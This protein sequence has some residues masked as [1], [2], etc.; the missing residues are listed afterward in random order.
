[1]KLLRIRPL[2]ASWVVG[3]FLGVTPAWADDLGLT[4]SADGGLI[5]GV[6]TPPAAPQVQVHQTGASGLNLA[7]HVPGLM[8]EPRTT[9]GGDFVAV[10]WPEA[11]LAGEIGAPALPVIRRFFTAPLGTTVTWTADAGNAVTLDSAAAGLTVL[12]NPVQ[13]PIPKIPGA[14]ESVPFVIDQAAYTQDISTPAERVTIEELGL[15]R[16]TRMFLLTVYPVAYNPAQ[17]AISYWPNISVE[18]SFEGSSQPPS[19]LNPMPGLRENVLNPDQ[20]PAMSRG[21]GNYLIIVASSLQS[22]ILP[23]ANAKAAQGFTVSSWVPASASNTAIKAYI[24][25]LWGGADAPDYVLLVGD[26]D[27]IPHWTGGG[28]GTPATDLNYVCMDG[29][30]SNAW[31]TPDIAIGRFAVRTTTQLQDVIDKVLLYENGPLPDL[32]YMNRAVFM[33]SQDNYTVSEGTHNYVIS[34]YMT[35]QGITSDKLYCHTYGA[36]SQQVRDAFNA[37]RF[38]GIYSGHGGN[39]YWADGPVFYQSDVNALTNVGMYSV[40]YSFSCVTG[41]YTD[42][43][44]FMETWLRTPSKGACAATGSSVNSYWTEDD[45]LEKK[46]FDVI[47]DGAY[48]GALELGPVWNATRAR[49]LAAMGTGA[50]SRRYFEM[51]N[52]LGDP[53]MPYNP[54]P[55]TGLGV[56]PAGDF[57]SGGFLGGPFTP[58]SQDYLLQNLN[59]TPLSYQVTVTQPWLS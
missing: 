33:A 51:Y 19:A 11:P 59:A 35:P 58:V 26:T 57:Y 44:C 22:T 23:F 6:A 55:P 4:L 47:Y 43:E 5:Q 21:A 25:G 38:Y 40:I 31:Q 3:L 1:M 37:G 48:G 16:G 30:S 12:V 56:S 36:T 24:Q 20:I 18:V 42:S 32:D 39:N 13:P 9:K 41:T 8:I 14:I 53:S 54:T 27:T 49:Y 28:E 17:Q 45:V 50:T 10:S 15:A 29:D 7:V 52:L 34:T 2:F 46:L